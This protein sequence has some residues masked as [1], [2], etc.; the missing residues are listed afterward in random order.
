MA[1]DA[2]A[3]GTLQNWEITFDSSGGMFSIDSNTGEL[4]VRADSIRLLTKS[5]RPLP[6]KWHG[7][8][9][10]ETRYRQRYVDLII[11]ESSRE[12]FRKR[13]A[14]ITRP[15]F[16]GWKACTSIRLPWLPF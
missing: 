4:T 11:N 16:S 13:S 12:V 7:L 3:V 9:D 1:T 15:F 8:S 6:E 10:Q 2:D 14:I 5:L